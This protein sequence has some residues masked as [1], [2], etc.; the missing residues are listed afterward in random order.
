MKTKLLLVVVLFLLAFIP[1]SV[2]QDVKAKILT[3]PADWKFERINFPFG[4][5]PELKFHGFEEL[6]FSPGMFDT[7]ALDYFTYIFVIETYYINKFDKETLYDFLKK[8][9]RGLSNSVASSKG[10]VVDVSEIDLKIKKV[11]KDKKRGVYYLANINFLDTFTNGQMVYLNMDIQPFIN[12]KA[13]KTYLIAIVS[14]KKKNFKKLHEI[15]LKILE[16]HK[17]KFGI[18]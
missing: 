3:E 5:A 8:Y 7:K 11:K 16:K 2:A 1:A 18:H 9:Y 10:N 4:F 15:R 14:P 13:N 17:K 12:E 6:R